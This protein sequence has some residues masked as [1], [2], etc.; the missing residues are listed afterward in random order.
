M[1]KN[2][3][4]HLGSGIDLTSY[5]GFLDKSFELS[6]P[7]LVSLG[8]PR[9]GEGVIFLSL[10]WSR[11]GEGLTMDACLLTGEMTESRR[12]SLCGVVAGHRSFVPLRMTMGEE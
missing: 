2:A 1:T 3:F 8:R 5:S 4:L 7:P 10:C 6:A 12:V 11:L 9:V